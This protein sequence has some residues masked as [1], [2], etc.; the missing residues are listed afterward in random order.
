MSVEVKI[1]E[2]LSITNI[3]ISH[4][5]ITK[6]APGTSYVQFSWAPQENDYER[7]IQRIQK[8]PRECEELHQ[9]RR[10]NQHQVSV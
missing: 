5:D 7:L 3:M 9:L 4:P 2:S 10:S 6:R 1:K 8:T